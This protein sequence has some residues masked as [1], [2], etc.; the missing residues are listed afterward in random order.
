M[1]DQAINKAYGSIELPAGL[2]R[3]LQE[4]IDAALETPMRQKKVIL[5]P[6][7]RLWKPALAAAAALVLLVLSILGLRSFRAGQERKAV[8]I[9]A[10]QPGEQNG[11]ALPENDADTLEAYSEVLDLYR[12]LLPQGDRKSYLEHGVCTRCLRY[13]R[14]DVLRK[15]GYALT[16]L[17]GDGSK[18]L[19]IGAVE[20]DGE[21]DDTLF[22][23]YYLRDGK[24][25]KLFCADV[26]GWRDLGEGKLLETANLE[27]GN[28]VYVLWQ[29][30]SDA[31]E[32][33]E[34][35]LFVE[36][37][38]L[39]QYTGTEEET[40]HRIE[41]AWKAY[42]GDDYALGTRGGEEISRE[43]AQDWIEEHSRFI[44]T[45]FTPLDDS[46][47]NEHPGATAEQDLL[48]DRLETQEGE[49][50]Q[51]LNEIGTKQEPFA[52]TDYGDGSPEG[53]VL[54]L[55]Q[56][57][58]YAS[59]KGVT[60][61]QVRGLLYAR[62]DLDAASAE[63]YAV[64]LGKLYTMDPGVFLQAWHD[65]GEPA[66]LMHHVTGVSDPALSK[67]WLQEQWQRRT[68]AAQELAGAGE[69]SANFELDWVNGIAVILLHGFSEDCRFVVMTEVL[70][71]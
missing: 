52:L 32:A 63:A 36:G 46:E 17:D 21:G 35:L 66:E 60:P 33:D 37:V 2:E 10:S 24:P 13:S 5:K 47:Q 50:L 20:A 16:D 62:E 19:L 25:E 34:T 44:R 3:R 9:P 1:T 54:L 58:G 57:E 67:L 45:C 15:V 71:P 7:K 70:Q 53:V 38:Q 23:V 55:A 49:L 28:S 27:F 4:K 59:E 12:R 68:Q 48:E 14:Q 18:E 61:E 56:M 64:L 41:M 8:L 65:A 69:T 6:R 11:I 42:K 22:D 31:A 30:R 43:E 40:W 39:V 51:I 29:F 26:F